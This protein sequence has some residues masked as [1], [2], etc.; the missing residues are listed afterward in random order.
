MR[1][2]RYKWFFIAPALMIYSIL[3]I[4][5]I[6]ISFGF[7]FTD[8][9][10]FGPIQLNG[11]SNY[12]ELFQ[13]T[14]FYLALKNNLIYAFFSIFV[15]VSL[16]LLLALIIDNI[17]VGKSFFRNILFMP[18]VLAWIAVG[19]LWKWIFNP[20]FGLVN[21]V[22]KAFNISSY[23]INWLGDSHL[24]LYPIIIVAIWKS[25]GY[26]MVI[27]LAGLQDIPEELTEAAYIDGA[28]KLQTTFKIIIPLLKP[29]MS[30]VLIL[31]L[32]DAFRVFDVFII[33]GSQGAAGYTE[34]LSTYLFKNAFDYNRF[35]YASSIAVIQFL[36]VIIISITYLKSMDRIEEPQ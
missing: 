24:I 1:F 6:I 7:G 9:K 25:F 26:A 11:I 14:R 18:M 23:G 34:V 10:G 17:K 32:I 13:D 2:Y 28:G 27:F 29:V 33:M 3:W 21:E 35:G 12:M 16:G 4:I 36:I 5:P 20:S 19:L 30:V 8:W 31:T 15:T 22:L